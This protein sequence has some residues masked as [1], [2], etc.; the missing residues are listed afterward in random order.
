MKENEL[1]STHTHTKIKSHTDY[2]RRKER[3][4]FFAE[5]FRD[6]HQRKRSTVKREKERES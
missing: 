3:A 1:C 6:T 4:D 5:P 2:G